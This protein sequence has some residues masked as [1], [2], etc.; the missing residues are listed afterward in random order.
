MQIKFSNKS[1]VHPDYDIQVHQS[2]ASISAQDWNALLASQSHPTPFMKHEYLLAMEQ[3]ESAT[4]STGWTPCFIT[5][6]S[7]GVLIAACPLYLKMHS[8]GEFVFDWAWANAY[9]Q[10]N[11]P[12]YPKA[13][14]AVPFTPVPGSRLL[15]RD[16]QTRRYLALVLKSF[17]DAQQLSSAHA[18][19]ASDEDLAACSKPAWM[20][21]RTV[22][23]H[24]QNQGYTDFADFL[25]HLNQEKRKKIKQERARVAKAGITMR[26]MWGEEITDDDWNFFYQCYSQTYYEHGNAPYL[27][28]DFFKRMQRTMARNWVLFKALKAGGTPVAASLVA[29]SDSVEENVVKPIADSPQSPRQGAC[30]MP[31]AYGRYWGALERV[32]CLHFEACY[33]S[34]IAWCIEHG[35]QS[36]EGGAQGE[37]KMARA[38]LPVKTSS[39][40]YV[41][42]PSFAQ[43]IGNFL[44]RE[45]KGIE[46]YMEDLQSRAPLK[47]ELGPV[48]I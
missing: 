13:L 15:A 39:A 45:E 34:P 48:T 38:L 44:Q 9:E 6:H 8:Y 30:K 47:I 7:L 31:T 14:V 18:L 10:H 3:S 26:A 27:T 23:F 1:N 2:V 36:F 28:P 33:Y 5:V 41:V 12:Y 46:H 21:R 25:S 11:L 29:L 24:W 20:L 42:H 17:T 40:H 37:H 22:Q 4:A 16:E 32:D 35:V 43:A 19:F